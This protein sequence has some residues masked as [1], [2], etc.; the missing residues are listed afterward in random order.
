MT[1]VPFT[2]MSGFDEPTSWPSLEPERVPTSR[3]GAC[4]QRHAAHASAPQ[5]RPAAVSE[6]TDPRSLLPPVPL[7][8]QARGWIRD[9]PLKVR[10]GL[11]ARRHPHVVNRL[12]AAWGDPALAQACFGDLLLADRVGRKG[13]S[14]EVLDEMVTLQ[15]YSL[16]LRRR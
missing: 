9:L 5:A 14:L 16:Q 11:T 8:P 2:P 1:I 15:R 10:P 4:M 3:E 12:V 6:A 13:F 7:T